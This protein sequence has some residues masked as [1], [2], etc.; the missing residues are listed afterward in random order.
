[1]KPK[2]KRAKEFK[3]YDYRGFE[4][5]GGGRN[6]HW[7]VAQWPTIYTSQRKAEE[8]VDQCLSLR[9]SLGQA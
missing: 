1:M 4:I 7:Y 2:Q 3:K 5:S 6:H 8:A 9:E